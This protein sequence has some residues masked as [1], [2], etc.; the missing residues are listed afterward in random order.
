MTIEWVP[1]VAK[2]LVYLVNPFLMILLNEFPCGCINGIAKTGDQPKF[3]VMTK[4]DNR[5]FLAFVI[6]K[7]H[8][9]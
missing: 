3:R 1:T 5:S 7:L 2:P 6:D 9:A 8:L 4:L